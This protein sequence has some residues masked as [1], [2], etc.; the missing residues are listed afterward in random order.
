MYSLTIVFGPA[1]WQFMFRTP[2]KLETFKQFRANNPAQDV[3]IDD[4]FG[5]HAEIKA[6]SIH[7]IQIENLE[8]TRIVHIERAVHQGKIQRD[9]QQRFSREPGV[10]VPVL[11]PVGMSPNGG[12][13][14]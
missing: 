13:R 1:A 8:E 14:Q 2:E 11:D 5:Q 4:D 6:A 10:R 9:A 12:V 7:G 3:I